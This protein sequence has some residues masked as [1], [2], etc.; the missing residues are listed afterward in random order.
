[1][2]VGPQTVQATLQAT[3]ITFESDET[4]SVTIEAGSRARVE[5]TVVV[6]D[7]PFVDLTF[8]AI[9]ENGYQDASKPTLATGPDGTIPVYRYTAPD[10]VGTGGMLR[11]EGARTEAISLPPSLDT[12]QGE[13]TLHLDPSLAVTTVDALDYLRNYPHQCIEQTIS[14]FLPNVMTYR[15]LKDLGLDDPELE[16]KLRQALGEALVKSNEQNPDGGWGWFARME[17]NPY[18]TA[19]AALGLLE[20]RDAGFDVEQAMI[21]RA[22]NFV[23]A[24]LVRP[25]IDTPVWQLNRQA[26]YAYVFARAGYAPTGNLDA[27]LDHRLELDH[28]ALSFLLM[29]YHQVDP[30][31]PAVAQLV[32]DLQSAAILSATGA[33]W[34]EKDVD[35]WNWSSDTR[36]TAIALAALTR[37]QPDHDTTQETAWA[38]MALTDWMVASGELR[39]NYEYQVI[40]NGDRLSERTV[41]PESIREGEVLRVQVKDLLADAINRVTITRGSGEGVLYYTAH[42]QT[43]LWASEA[44]PVSRGISVSREFFLADT[45]VTRAT[46]GDVI[47]VRVTITLPQDIYY[48]VLEDPIPAGTEPVDTSLL[49]T[50]RLDQT[51]TI[52]PEYDPRWYWGWWLFDHTEMRDEQVNLYADFLPRGTYVYTYQVRA[53][54]PGEFQTMPSHAYAFYFPEV[55]GRGAGTLFTIAPPD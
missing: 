4:Q 43:R 7:V 54:I 29:A 47:T 24:N 40:V 21:D 8:F 15:A 33:H 46:T 14:R 13:L 35:W 31:A 37:V 32:S 48:F 5:W 18:I 12:D 23:I 38:V 45:P 49:T 42:L 50:S 51:P 19:Y 1:V 30:E 16:A 25:T 36:S 28:W 53:T 20:A 26:F 10:T 3:G 11:I 27:L 52:R 55:F 22:L 39:G 41:T 6:Q 2:I 34:E 17:S 44:K 9:G